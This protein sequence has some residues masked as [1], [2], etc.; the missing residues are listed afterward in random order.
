MATHPLPLG[1]ARENQGKRGAS[2]GWTGKCGWV[3]GSDE[4]TT[5]T[6][7]LAATANSIIKRGTT[8]KTH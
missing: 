2:F 8:H 4:C 3:L 5:A 1:K 7:T 6:P